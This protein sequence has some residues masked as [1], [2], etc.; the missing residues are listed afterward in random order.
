MIEFHFSV[1]VI[2][3]R[4]IF[5]IIRFVFVLDSLS[6]LNKDFLIVFYI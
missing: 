2:T 6:V 4:I 5:V 3:L 1:V